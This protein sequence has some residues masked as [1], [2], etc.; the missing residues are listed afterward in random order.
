M[1]RTSNYPNGFG[2]GVDILGMPILN[3]YANDVFWVNSSVSG[4]GGTRQQPF[5]TIQSALDKCTAGKGDIIM[6]G[7]GHA[8]TVATAGALDLDIADIS[9]IGLGRGAKRPT[10]TF[11]GV[12]GADMDINAANITI[13]NFLFVAGLDNLTAP[14]DVNAAYFSML[15]CETRDNN[16]AIHTDDFIVTDANADN[17]LIDG[18]YHNAD[19]GK[20]GAQ[21]AISI[22]G[23]DEIVIKN[24]DITGDFATAGIENVTTTATNIRIYNDNVGYI[25]T[26][27]SADVCIALHANCTGFIGPNINAKLKDNAANIT[28]AFVGAAAQF[29]QPINI[30]NL[31]GEVGMQT[32]ITASTDA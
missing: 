6:V 23:G 7:P 11:N 24:F 14:I 19:G 4:N 30:C 21:T 9:I 5:N 8:E 2:N 29:M 27:N 32:N 22:I 31:V 26:Q 18:W 10:I 16:A 1:Q 17:L 25:W 28:A 3:T 13:V 12:I 20:T 15:G